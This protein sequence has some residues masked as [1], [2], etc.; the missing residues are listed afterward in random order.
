MANIEEA[1]EAYL[2]VKKENPPQHEFGGFKEIFDKM[3]KGYVPSEQKLTDEEV[4]RLMA[5]VSPSELSNEF[6]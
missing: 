3:G 6:I 2:R 5:S 4:D 1:Y